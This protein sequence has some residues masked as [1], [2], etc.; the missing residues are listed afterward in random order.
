MDG[1]VPNTWTI[2]ERHVDFRLTPAEPVQQFEFV[3]KTRGSWAI[4]GLHIESLDAINFSE[5]VTVRVISS[6]VVRIHHHDHTHV[7]RPITSFARPEAQRDNVVPPATFAAFMRPKVDIWSS[8]EV[9]PATGYRVR[10]YVRIAEEQ[11]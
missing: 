4:V 6:L 7:N 5:A 10:L 8:K 11:P 9:L 3:P 2:S 1:A